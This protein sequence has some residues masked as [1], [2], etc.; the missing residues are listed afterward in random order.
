MF[1][2]ATP[3]PAAPPLVPLPTP[4][5][6]FDSESPTVLAGV[7]DARDV[8]EFGF[9]QPQVAIFGDQL[10]LFY[11]EDDLDA[12][13]GPNAWFSPDWPFTLLF[14]VD[15]Y[16][17]GLQPPDPFLVSQGVPYNVLDQAMKGQAA[18]DQFMGL[19]L[20]SFVGPGLR[21][22]RTG[23]STSVHNNFDEGGTSFSATPVGTSETEASGEAQ[24]DVDS[25]SGLPSAGLA[26]RMPMNVYFTV[27]RES[28]S[29]DHL[30]S[31]GPP[32]GSNIYFSANPF[33][34]TEVSL[35]ASFDQL[36]LDP[37]DDINALIIFDLDADGLYTPLDMILF[38]LDPESPSL[39]T[40]GSAA[41]VFI[42]RQDF[43][44]E[45]FATASEFGLGAPSDNIDALDFLL[46]TDP[47]DAALLHGIRAPRGDMN[48]DGV[49]DFHD[50]NVFVLALSNPDAYHA[51]FPDCDILQADTNYDGVVDFKD[52]NRFVMLLSLPMP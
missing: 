36:M 20:Y 40:L 45:V 11:L 28:P 48:C 8:L 10:Q 39:A 5:Y 34:P 50:I 26:A 31:S 29:L 9:P 21:N 33:Q 13:S 46:T 38:S 17:E 43:Y 24:D 41:D 1:L 35:Y 15:R 44:T 23:N 32:S 19:E 37:N 3:A 12:I 4:F 16:T 52:I 18:G 25:T 7:L 30:P 47:I 22:V 42:A 27:T 49:L 51:Q 2:L 6:S 14:S